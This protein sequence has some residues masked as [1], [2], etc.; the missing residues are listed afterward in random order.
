VLD[1]VGRR[2]IGRVEQRCGRLVDVVQ[3]G[4][5]P[6]I[7]RLYRSGPL[8]SH[9]ERAAHRRNDEQNAGKSGSDLVRNPEIS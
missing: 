4:R 6:G 9:E 8:Q 5:H 2:A 3:E 1:R 7:R